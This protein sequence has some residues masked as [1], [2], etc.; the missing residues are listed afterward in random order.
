MKQKQTVYIDE[1]N[2]LSKTGNSVYVCVFIKYFNKK[3]I[4]NRIQSIEKDLK[5]SYTHW[6]DMPWKLRLR[7]AEKIKDLDFCCKIVIYKNPIDQK[8]TLADFLIKSVSLEDNVHEIIIDGKQSKIFQLKF[9]SFL[10]KSGV[11]VYKLSFVNDKS[12]AL[13]RLSDFVAGMYRSY[14]DNICLRTI[15]LYGLLKDKIKTLN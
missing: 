12:D 9:K 1:S 11:K 6:V 5:I 13:I 15:H 4:N 3:L 10:R 7:F 2:I 8:N 14:L